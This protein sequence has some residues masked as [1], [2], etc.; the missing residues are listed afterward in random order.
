MVHNRHLRPMCEKIS[1]GRFMFEFNTPRKRFDK[2][3]MLTMPP[4]PD[5]AYH[6][7]ENSL[8]LFV[9][10][11]IDHSQACSNTPFRCP[12][13]TGKQTGDEIRPQT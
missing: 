6:K 2:D 10:L 12:F 7:G 13:S 9:S 5:D 1:T 11:M 4:D 3:T 8:V